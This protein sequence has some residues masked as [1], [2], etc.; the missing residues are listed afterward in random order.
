MYKY[1]RIIIGVELYWNYLFVDKPQDSELGISGALH[2][3]NGAIS[4]KSHT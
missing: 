3:I 1:S 4:F 2:H